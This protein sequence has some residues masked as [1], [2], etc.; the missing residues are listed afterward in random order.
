[1]LLQHVTGTEMKVRRRVTNM[2]VSSNLAIVVGSLPKTV[3]LPGC[4]LPQSDSP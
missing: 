4:S 1:M 2:S 3:R